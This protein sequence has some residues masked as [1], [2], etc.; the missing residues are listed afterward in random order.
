MVQIVAA[1]AERTLSSGRQDSNA[2]LTDLTY[3]PGKFPGSAATL[4][5]LLLV[6][7]RRHCLQMVQIVAAQ[8]ERTL[9]SGRQDSNAHLTDLTYVPGKFPGL[10]DTRPSRIFEFS[11]GNVT[12]DGDDE[13]PTLNASIGG[14]CGCRAE[15]EALCNATQQARSGAACVSCARAC[16]GLLLWQMS[17]AMSPVVAGM[18]PSLS[19][20]SGWVIARAWRANTATMLGRDF[21]T[22]W[23]VEPRSVATGIYSRAPDNGTVYNSSRNVG[24]PML[25]MSNGLA[26]NDR[27][28]RWTQ[29]YWNVV[30]QTVMNSC[31]VAMWTPHGELLAT[32][33]VDLAMDVSKAL[34]LNL[35]IDSP[36]PVLAVM[37]Q[38]SGAVVA[39]PG[40][41]E[42]AL[43]GSCLNHL[44]NV[45]NLSSDMEKVA[46]MDLGY[47]QYVDVVIGGR[48]YIVFAQSLK[49][50]WKLWFFCLRSDAFPKSEDNTA[51][52]V[53][54]SVVIPLAVLCSAFAAALVALHRRMQ[55]RVHELEATLGSV[56]SVNVIGTPAEDAIKMLLEVQKK[57]RMPQELKGDLNR[58]VALIATNKLFKADSNLR[59]KLQE[60]HLETEV[61]DFLVNVLATET[62]RHT[63]ERMGETQSSRQMSGLITF[64]VCQELDAVATVREAGDITS[65]N[66][67]V[68]CIRIPTG[69]TLLEVVGM[70]ILESDGLISELGLDYR[71][72]QTFLRSIEALYR[73]NPY[74]NARH[75]ADVAQ[76][77]YALVKGCT[78]AQFTP[79]ERLAAVVAAV[80]HDVGHPGVNN[81]FLQSTMD[82][83]HVRYNGAS[84]LES[85]HSAE[86]MRVLLGDE[87]NFVRGKLPQADV[88]ELHR[89]VASMVLATDMSRHLEFTSQLLMLQLILKA[90]DV[91]NSSRRWEVCSRWARRV[92]EEFGQQG[93]QERERGL[94]VSAFMDRGTQDIGR[95]QTAFIKYVMLPMADIVAKISP[96]IGRH[97]ELSWMEVIV[98]KAT[99][100]VDET[101]TGLTQMVQVVAAQ[102]E[103][104]LSE[105]QQDMNVRLADL[106]YISGL[107]PGLV[108]T[109]SDRMFEFSIGN[110]THNDN[111]MEDPTLNAS[112]GGSC[113][114]RAQWEALCNA[115]EQARNGTDMLGRDAKAVWSVES[116]SVATDI[117]SRAPL[118]QT[119]YNSSRDSQYPVLY[120]SDGLARYDRTARWSQPYWNAARKR[121]MN[122]CGVAIWAPDGELLG[123]LFVDL[124]MNV[125]KTLFLNLT[126]NSRVPVLSVMAQSSGAVVATLDSTETELWGTCPD[127]LCNVF[128]L[129]A[130]M[131]RVARMDLGSSEYVDVAIGGRDYIVFAQ[132][133]RLG[134]KLWFFCLRSDAF[135]SSAAFI[136]L[137]RTMQKRVRDLEATLGSVASVNVIGTPAEDAIKVLLEVQKKAKMPHELKGDL[138]KVVALI[139]TN[140]MF[141]ADSN[142]REKLQEFLQKVGSIASWDFD[143]ESIVVPPDA[144]L[145]EVVGM[146][147]L[148]S[149]GLITEL[150]LDYRYV[151]TFLRSI[152]AQYRDNPY[153]NA[154]HA[155]D[156]AQAT[157][158]LVKG[159]TAA[160]F[161]PLE[162][163]AA[164]VAAVIHDVGHPGVNNAFLQSTMDALHVR[165]NGVSVLESMHSAEGMRVLLS[166]ECNFVRGK[167][168]QADVVELHRTVASM[169]LATDMSRH[170][171]FTSQLLILQLILKAADVSNSSRRWEVCARWARRVM[172]E[173]GQQGDQERERGLTVSAF[174]DRG[175]QD[176]GRCQTAFIKYVMLP[177]A[178]IVAKISPAIGRHMYMNLEANSLKWST[179]SP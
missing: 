119:V 61:N 35:T 81:A 139:A 148:E 66:F 167:L 46:L 16:E 106:T 18:A 132:N 7:A 137:H 110:V 122:G 74:H 5:L 134:W 44:C 158:A 91:S 177:M 55:K 52:V 105:G 39:A 129:S 50:G 29:P 78:T 8:A 143:I 4:A 108:N 114:C 135:P 113:G 73:D 92:M 34:F 131:E 120:M 157:Y 60:F 58:V 153:H 19:L 107:Y 176:I 76:A 162:R 138:N 133:L 17:S 154:R 70:A 72:V 63:G 156:V 100:T 96:V 165:Y 30:R 26:R 146:A 82:A 124:A 1:Q 42:D 93:D 64:R 65:W 109:E 98:L 147:I 53:S 130:D 145:L 168:P 95:C 86:G 69:A 115:T 121:V 116:Y 97:I 9:S 164:V 68:E 49:L 80:I 41:T 71:Y 14:S 136:V 117:Y 23:S 45:F 150:G 101:Y 85:M 2:H 51:M 173:F 170:L 38:S 40:R 54:V 48:D 21:K 57:A 67:D 175:T 179:E 161:T 94:T 84:V 62:Q 140:K 169:V 155:A 102:A 125:S 104:L 83:L 22:V 33:F 15:W 37:A 166:D 88:V 118:N 127:H 27:A 99:S 3:V 24:Y 123:T 25:P 163:L 171:E 56:A 144:T 47:S 149:D 13:D 28:P 87:C 141:K 10:V 126:I 128:N 151:Q 90:A 152:E 172:E 11:I 111:D 178:D 112:I 89:T 36:V 59:E 159:C 77:T 20:V 43:W 75:A 32:L 103:S 79:L 12:H 160:Q 142:L 174:M 6:A 31:G